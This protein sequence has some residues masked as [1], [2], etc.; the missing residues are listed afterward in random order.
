MSITPV[1]TSIKSMISVINWVIQIENH[2]DALS[3]P[4]N[5]CFR[6][7]LSISVVV[8]NTDLV[9]NWMPRSAT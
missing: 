1:T 6:K 9:K 7:G 5:G 8:G 2:M 3:T 4:K